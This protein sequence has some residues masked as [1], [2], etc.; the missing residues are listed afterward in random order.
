MGRIITGFGD[1]V[2]C[3]ILP[4]YNVGAAMHGA[5]YQI[6]ASVDDTETLA[7]IDVNRANWHKSLISIQAC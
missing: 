7:E 3:F 4:L 1:G 5:S 2:A 6:S